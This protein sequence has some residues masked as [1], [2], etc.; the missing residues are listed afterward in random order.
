MENSSVIKTITGRS[1]VVRGADID[2]DRI[3]PA[4]FLR[5]V[6]FENLGAHAF[7]DD[8]VGWRPSL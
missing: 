5:T 4:R 2:T 3:I 6:T 1:V 7:E 8:R